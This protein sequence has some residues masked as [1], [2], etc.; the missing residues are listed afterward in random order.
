MRKSG[1]RTVR[2]IVFNVSNIRNW[3]G[4]VYYAHNI[5]NLMLHS[6]KL[7]NLYE[8]HV[9]ASPYNAYVFKKYDERVKLVEVDYGNCYLNSAYL[10]WYMY[11]YKVDCWYT[12][13]LNLLERF[14]VKKAILW[15]AD[16]QYL[17][18]PQFFSNF[19][20][21][22]RDAH[23]RYVAKQRNILVLSSE[24]AKK[25]FQARY[26]NYKCQCKVVHF[27]SNIEDEIKGITAG[28]ELETLKK[29]GLYQQKYVYIPNQFWQHK[30]HIVV[31]KMIKQYM[32]EG[33]EG[34]MF[35]F[36]GQMDDYRNKGY[37]YD[38][39]KHFAD[40]E[41]AKVT[42]NLGF[43]SRR[44]QL[45]I[46]KNAAFLIQPSLFEGWGTVL[47]DAKVLDKRVILSDL[48][49]H[50]EQKY[51][52]CTFFKRRDAL[53]LLKKVK[54]LLGEN[55]RDDLAEGIERFNSDS[56]RY[57]KELEQVLL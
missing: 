32:A 54:K 49:V 52:K 1:E 39:K 48:S 30:N 23:A 50:K 13:S 44:E 42:K 12:M 29:Y 57:A 27:A 45:V 8:I 34:V 37:I 55:S 3:M 46:M 22:M 24:D 2:K 51:E 17:H 40:M 28:E 18:L 20:F 26:K 31:L 11:R 56:V 19:D 43:L 36:T 10:I 21:K 15:I 16:F 4:G 47:E 7:S 5:I 53:D 35:V 41:I 9:L 38:L 14:I 33:M 25:D 6:E